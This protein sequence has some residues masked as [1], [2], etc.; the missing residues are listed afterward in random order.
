MLGE[1]IATMDKFELTTDRIIAFVL[2]CLASVFAVILFW[3]E[4][5]PTTAAGSLVI[6]TCLT[7][8]PILIF[9]KTWFA[10][11]C[12][13][14]ALLIA[15]GLFGRFIWPRDLAE[16]N[17]AVDIQ[18]RNDSLPIAASPDGLI[19][20]MS[21][22][23]KSDN[24]GID[25]LIVTQKQWPDQ[26][27]LDSPNAKIGFSK[28]IYKC[29]VTNKGTSRLFDVGVEFLLYKMPF[30]ATDKPLAYDVFIESLVPDKPFTF[31]AINSCPEY[32]M[33]EIPQKYRARLLGETERRSFDTHKPG[34]VPMLI[35]MTLSA[36]S[37]NWMNRS[38]N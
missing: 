15:V 8:Y 16:V 20:L 25:D 14:V 31:Y 27:Q 28:A 11:I 2:F 22:N 33:V 37:E 1:S 32:V 24:T 17:T 6:I 9:A 5:T 38:C 18:C 34:N 19:N 26:K 36:S 4:K 3:I 13:F 29:E 12:L 10:R 30:T 21:V 7:I 23:Q 35:P